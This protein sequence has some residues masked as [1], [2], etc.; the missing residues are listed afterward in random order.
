MSRVCDVTGRKSNNANNVSHA[1][2]KSKRLQHANLQMKRIVDPET[3]KIYKLKLS[4]RALKTLNKI[5]SVKEFLK[6]YNQ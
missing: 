3:G 6:K 5:G 1:N 4:T 2:N